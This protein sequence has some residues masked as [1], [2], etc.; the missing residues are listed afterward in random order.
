MSSEWNSAATGVCQSQ[1]Y[2]VRKI[3]SKRFRGNNTEQVQTYCKAPA[4]DYKGGYRLASKI[5][6]EGFEADLHQTLIQAYTVHC[7]YSTDIPVG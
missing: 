2:S 3:P 1:N 7:M 5:K 4:K 6:D